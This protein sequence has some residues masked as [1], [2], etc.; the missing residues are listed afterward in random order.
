MPEPDEDDMETSLVISTI[1]LILTL[2]LE[3]VIVAVF[4]A[5]IVRPTK[6][7]KKAEER[8]EDYVP[9]RF[10]WHCMNCASLFSGTSSWCAALAAAIEHRVDGACT[11]VSMMPHLR[12]PA[13]VA[14]SDR[15][16]V[17]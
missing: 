4:G 14:S 10:T 3:V 7:S 8:W 2:P 6:N 12:V 17:D 16:N 1:S 11:G 9:Y 15:E 5:F 13:S